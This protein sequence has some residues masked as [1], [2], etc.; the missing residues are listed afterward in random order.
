M[1]LAHWR[2][3]LDQASHGTG[4]HRRPALADWQTSLSALA[5]GLLIAAS[6]CGGPAPTSESQP[7]APQPESV[8]VS[9]TTPDEETPEEVISQFLDGARRGGAA[10][11]VGRLMTA[12]AR[13]TYASVG[14]VMQP[15]GSPDAT[16]EVTRSVPYGDGGALVNSIWTEQDAAGQTVTYQVGW[17]LKKETDGWRV[18]G[19]ILEDDP[20]P[21]VFNFESRADVLAI[22]QLQS[23]EPTP[24]GTAPAEQTRSAEA[25]NF[26]MPELR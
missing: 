12:T 15:P 10:A 23:G 8:S 20:E 2:P 22:K 21:R 11:D 13:E 16:F 18:S 4:I 25:S 26:Q 14:L 6:G 1:P 9:S 5:L 7:A 19:L 17:A 3:A 24:D